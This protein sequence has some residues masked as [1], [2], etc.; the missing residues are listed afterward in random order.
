VLGF[1]KEIDVVIL[2]DE[3]TNAEALALESKLIDIFDLQSRGGMLVNLDEGHAPIERRKLYR[4]ELS[5][6]SKYWREFLKA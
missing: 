1:G 3:L 5:Q 2:S 4:N 6:V